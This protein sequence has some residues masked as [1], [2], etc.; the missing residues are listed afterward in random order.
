MNAEQELIALRDLVET[1]ARRLDA[2]SESVDPARRGAL[3]MTRAEAVALADD[4]DQLVRPPSMR[5]RYL[6][7]AGAQDGR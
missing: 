2:L 5:P 4:L 3:R 6:A 1:V 7:S